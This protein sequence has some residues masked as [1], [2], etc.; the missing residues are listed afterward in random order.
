MN[1]TRISGIFLRRHARHRALCDALKLAR[2]CEITHAK[3][4][5]SELEWHHR[6]PATKVKEISQAYVWSRARLL[7][8]LAKCICVSK[9][10]HVELHRKR[11]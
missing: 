7:R 3:L 10:A 9:T 5:P 2:G 1:R 11:A 4:P 8:E 6:D